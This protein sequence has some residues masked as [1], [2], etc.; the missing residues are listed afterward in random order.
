MTNEITEKLKQASDGL[1]MMS[2]SEYP[3]E[4]F[5]WSNQA[6][7]PMTTQK[8]LQLTGHSLETSIEEVE[9]DYFFRNCAE[10]KEW[11]D[12]IQKQNVS[13]FK[14]LVKILK[15]HLTDIKVYR[16]GT[17]NLDIYIVGKTPST[18]LAGISTK[19]VET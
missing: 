2:E 16:I 12:E 5:L 13:K 18:D 14:S 11:H 6:Q 4:A 9:L 8:L 15:D 10:E 19:V 17:I 7:E 3:F 1:L